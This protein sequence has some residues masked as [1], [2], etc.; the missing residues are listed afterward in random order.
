MKVHCFGCEVV[1]EAD[2][3]EGIVR[4][5]LAHARDTHTWTYPEQALRNF[6]LNVA[7]AEARLTGSTERLAEIGAITIHAVSEDRIPDWLQFFDHDGFAG[8]PG[9]AA[10]YC[11]EPNVPASPEMP[12]RYWRDSRGAVCERI[13]LRT[14]QGYLAYVEERPA[15]WVNASLRSDYGLFRDVDPEGP[16][17]RSVI[18]VS[19]FVVAPPYRRHG[20]AAAL[21][22]RVIADAPSRGAAWIEAYPHSKPE[23][24]DAGH[25]RGARSMYEA[26]GFLEVEQKERCTVMRRPATLAPGD[27]AA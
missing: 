21:L 25:F 20:V 2:D 1:L 27:A 24:G 22:D 10:C 14:T 23:E 15:G 3:S 5:F 18:G 4:V 13:R 19:C 8:N 9:W 26:R 16:A 17:P 6:A 12:E 7:E 11:L